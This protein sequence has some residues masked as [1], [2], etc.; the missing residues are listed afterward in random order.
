MAT[1]LLLYLLPV[2]RDSMN[3]ST[4]FNLLYL[5]SNCAISEG[6]VFNC[7]LI[8]LCLGIYQ[9]KVLSYLERG[10]SVFRSQYLVPQLRVNLISFPQLRLIIIL[11]RLRLNERLSGHELT[12]HCHKHFSHLVNDH[13]VLGSCP[14]ISTSLFWHPMKPLDLLQGHV[15]HEL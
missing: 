14:Y 1:A 2:D 13:R 10:Y 5:S 11:F 7:N 6:I 3:W 4:V 12:T 8:P 15:I 9:E